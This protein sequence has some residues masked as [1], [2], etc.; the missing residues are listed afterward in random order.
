M[1]T[2]EIPRQ[3]VPRPPRNPGFFSGIEETILVGLEALE[4]PNLQGRNPAEVRLEEQL[5]FGQSY[6]E[7]ESEDVSGLTDWAKSH[8]SRFVGFR[9][10]SYHP[11]L[12]GHK[13]DDNKLEASRI[14]PFIP[15]KILA[16]KMR[17]KYVDAMGQQGIKALEVFNNR[18]A[19]EGAS[20][21]EAGSLFQA[22][23]EIMYDRDSV[24]LA[25]SHG[26][27]LG[28]VGTLAGAVAM[29]A[30]SKRSR[31]V[32]YCGTSISKSLVLQEYFGKLV[33][34]RF[35]FFGKLYLTVP[36]TSSTGLY[37]LPDAGVHR[38]RSSSTQELLN[39]LDR[40]KL[41]AFTTAPTAKGMDRKPGVDKET[42][43]PLEG[44][45]VLEQVAISLTTAN[46]I[47]RFGNFVCVSAWGD[48]VKA[49]GV[50]KLPSLEGQSQ[51]DKKVIA[52]NNANTISEMLAQ[53]TADLSQ[54][55][56]VY[57]IHS[58]E[59]IIIKGKKEHKLVRKIAFPQAA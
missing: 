39:D 45:E 27:S 47:S 31:L 43:Q 36:D 56:V 57:H 7:G 20:L 19:K 40:G 6:I 59:I 41:R 44:P 28:D 32:K 30:G 33:P 13:I 50:H 12:P 49:S 29:S 10:R 15:R 4:N 52:R 3:G 1:G 58:E 21:E 46:L 16:K 23:G 51:K 17:G 11:S 38:V 5:F 48:D 53:Q 2:F 54:I 24:F 25:T 8:Q 14:I 22:L 9:A 55:P 42:G 37:D 34:E 35:K 18:P 26:E